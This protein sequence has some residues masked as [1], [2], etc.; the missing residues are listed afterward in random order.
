MD[1]LGQR[2]CPSFSWCRHRI[3]QIRDRWDDEAVLTIVRIHPGEEVR[4]M[5]S[6]GV[7]SFLLPRCPQ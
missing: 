4:M 6:V 2:C 1:R 3:G 5:M 7:D